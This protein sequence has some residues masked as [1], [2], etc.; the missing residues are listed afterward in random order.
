MDAPT[1]ADPTATR[2]AVDAYFAGL[3]A[4]KDWQRFFSDDVVFTSR[5]SP[6]RQI[7][8][9]STFVEATK[10]FY[11]MIAQVDVLQ[12]IV[13]GDRACA[14]THYELNP[15]A[16]PQFESDVAEIFHV[17]DGKI[18]AFDIYFDSA[19]YPK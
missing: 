10:R 12:L 11:S 5:T 19:P 9:R 2:A 1:K 3:A 6:N 4:G 15:P 17:R 13:D 16:G 7:S 14:L 18:A 8:G